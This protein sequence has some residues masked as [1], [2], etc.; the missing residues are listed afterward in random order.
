MLKTGV[1][2]VKRVGIVCVQMRFAFSSRL[3]RPPVVP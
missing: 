3:V 1:N 2:Y